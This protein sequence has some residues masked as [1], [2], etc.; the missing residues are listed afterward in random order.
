MILKVSAADVQ[1]LPE[2]AVAR[3]LRR[4]LD[5]G[6]PAQV[7]ADDIHDAGLLCGA[8]HLFRL[9]R[10]TREWLLA[11][12]MFAGADR[13]QR[14]V[15]MEVGRGRDC[16]EIHVGPPNS[17]LPSDL[18]F[19]EVQPRGRRARALLVHFADDQAA[20][21]RQ[22]GKEERKNPPGRR[23]GA[24]DEASSHEREPDLL[25]QT[26]KDMRITPDPACNLSQVGC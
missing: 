18:P 8:A 14:H 11:K 24:R 10:R 21:P 26:G 4:L 7:E 2:R 20:Q 12:D 13:C 17:L 5:G 16:H 9:R 15:A 1:D 22:L 6:S 3:H 19:L 25:H 23:M